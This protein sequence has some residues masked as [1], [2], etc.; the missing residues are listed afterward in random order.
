MKLLRQHATLVRFTAVLSIYAFLLQ[1]CTKWKAQPLEPERFAA[2]K[3]P[4]SVRITLANGARATASHPW[5][6][7]DSLLWKL[8]GSRAKD[9]VQRTGV[10]LADV[11]KVEV[12]GFDAVRTTVY[13]VVGLGAVVAIVAASDPS[14]GPTFG[15]GGGGGYGGESCPVVYSW[16]GSDWRLDSG[17]FGG[18][19]VAALARS[20]VDNLDFVKPEAGSVRLKLANVLNETEYV[21]ALSLLLV[22]HD[23]DVTVA[24]DGAGRLH[25]VGPLTHAL[26]AHDYLGRDALARIAAADGW[27]WES[28]PTQRDP[29]ATADLRDGIELAFARPAGARAVRLVVDGNNT[30][31]AARSLEA[32]VALHGRATQAWYDSL[33]A[34]PAATQQLATKFAREA[35]LTVSVWEG[36]TWQPHG[37]MWE[38]SPEVV[39]RQVLPLDLSRVAGD[40]VRLRLESI[41]S[42]WLLDQVALDFSPERPLTTTEVA[43]ASGRDQHGQDVRDPLAAVDHRFL[44]LEPGD[45]S[46][47]RFTVP[48]VPAGRA[49]TH[50]VRSTGWYRLH[51]GE[52]A[53]PDVTLLTRTVKEPLG[54]AQLS[55]AMMNDALAAMRLAAR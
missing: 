16:D 39:K 21:D 35:F 5:I 42:F 53:E 40:T 52:A 22:D 15:G 6:E 43:A 19:I 51:T 24:P 1:G 41:P 50:L 36:G 2:S 30:A 26:T 11:A 14:F 20:D 38:A 28:S 4:G 29:H 34:A 12:R 44:T 49:R 13:V 45:F 37:L 7:N 9:P 55:V 54:F 17:T 23:P 31:W 46:E 32:L 48:D 8:E 27:S 10:P 3:S 33:N 47:L 18:A 25:T